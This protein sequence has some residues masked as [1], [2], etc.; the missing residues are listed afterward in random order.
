MTEK[1]TWKWPNELT[2]RLEKV[3]SIVSLVTIDRNLPV[4]N[5]VEYLYFQIYTHNTGIYNTMTE[6]RWWMLKWVNGYGDV[7]TIMVMT[8]ITDGAI[9]PYF[10]PD[11]IIRRFTFYFLLFIIIFIYSKWH[12]KFAVT[13][14]G[15]IYYTSLLVHI[16]LRWLYYKWD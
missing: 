16:I 3:M 11:T 15:N 7:V 9:L 10:S 4:Q 12:C 2:K 1:M 6:M 13:L 14:R 8:L 5:N